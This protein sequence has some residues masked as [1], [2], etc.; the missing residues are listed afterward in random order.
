MCSHCGDEWDEGCYSPVKAGS[1]PIDSETKPPPRMAIAFSTPARASSGNVWA[2]WREQ[3]THTSSVQPLTQDSPQMKALDYPRL[4]HAADMVMKAAQQAAASRNAMQAQQAA[5]SKTAANVQAAASKKTFKAVKQNAA[6]ADKATPTKIKAKAAPGKIGAEKT[7][8]DGKAKETP[9][10]DGAKARRL[11]ESGNKMVAKAAAAPP[12]KV[13]CMR[14]LSEAC[15]PIK[16]QQLLTPI[17]T[18]T[19]TGLG[20]SPEEDKALEMCKNAPPADQLRTFAG[21]KI[22][23]S[24]DEKAVYGA[25]TGQYFA[26]TECLEAEFPDGDVKLIEDSEEA[27]KAYWVFL[28]NELMSAHERICSALRS[29][30]A[31]S[32][33]ASSNL[34][35]EIPTLERQLLAVC[36]AGAIWFHKTRICLLEKSDHACRCLMT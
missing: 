28:S 9:K 24:K 5:A 31:E 13:K 2:A 36:M 12:S 6:D 1:K 25:I 30:D 27:Q 26:M 16:I 21:H 15:L 22:P 14:D 17:T 19:L 23:T 10:K 33:S 8:N 7:Q 11:P 32:S 20:L 29:A 3:E 34:I 4:P 35:T 18:I